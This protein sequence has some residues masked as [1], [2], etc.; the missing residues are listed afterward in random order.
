MSMDESKFIVTVAFGERICRYQ[1]NKLGIGKYK[2]MGKNRSV[3]ITLNHKLLEGQMNQLCVNILA[4]AIRYKEFY[5]PSL[6][7][8]ASQRPSL[9]REIQKHE[10]R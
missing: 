3:T 8:T 7:N 4:E 5:K 6:V 1:V 10:S 9:L 2:V